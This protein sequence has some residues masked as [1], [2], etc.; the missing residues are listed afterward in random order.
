[1]WSYTHILHLDIWEGNSYSN[2]NRRNLNSQCLH[3]N[4]QATPC[5]SINDEFADNPDEGIEKS[6]KGALSNKFESQDQETISIYDRKRKPKRDKIY[7][8]YE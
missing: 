8:Y 3:T 5:P 2:P 1:M 4:D 6:N 7:E